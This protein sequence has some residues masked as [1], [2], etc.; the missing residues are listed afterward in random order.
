MNG[1]DSRGQLGVHFWMHVIVE[2]VLSPTGDSVI[3]SRTLDT[4]ASAFIVGDPRGRIWQQ[5]GESLQAFEKR[6][7]KDVKA[8]HPDDER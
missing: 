1:G 5:P 8:L 3:G 4:D 7:A 2:P 6:L